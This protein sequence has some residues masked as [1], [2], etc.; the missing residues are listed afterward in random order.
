MRFPENNFLLFYL[1]GRSADLATHEKTNTL[2]IPRALAN[3]K[4]LRAVRVMTSWWSLACRYRGI[5]S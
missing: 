1:C 3:T 2:S 4:K 5:S